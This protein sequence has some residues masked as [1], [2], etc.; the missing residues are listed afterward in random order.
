VANAKEFDTGPSFLGDGDAEL[1]F[2]LSAG[3]LSNWMQRTGFAWK[4]GP[5]Q[6]PGQLLNTFKGADGSLAFKDNA[7][8]Q[9]VLIDRTPKDAQGYSSNTTTIFVNVRQGWV[10]IVYH[11]S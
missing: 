6:Q 9:Y 5:Y 11:D 4:R 8:V 7:D 10:L 1:S 3:E 2:E